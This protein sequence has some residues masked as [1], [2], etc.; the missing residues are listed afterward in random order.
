MFWISNI[1]LLIHQMCCT[2]SGLPDAKQNSSLH[3]LGSF[4]CH[5]TSTKL[6]LQWSFFGRINIF[7]RVL[8]AIH[9]WVNSGHQSQCV[10]FVNP[11]PLQCGMCS[12]WKAPMGTEW[13]GPATYWFVGLMQR[14]QK[15]PVW[16]KTTRFHQSR[17]FEL[18]NSITLI[19]SLWSQTCRM[20]CSGPHPPPPPPPCRS[21]R[22]WSSGNAL[23]ERK[24][25]QH[26]GFDSC[27]FAPA[28]L[29]PEAEEQVEKLIRILW[30]SAPRRNWHD[31]P[32]RDGWGGGSETSECVFALC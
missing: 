8:V 31:A 18:T 14:P 7:L 28:G 10:C 11:F 5:M 27:Q 9:R 15:L 24:L 32:Q 30:L 23:D 3:W 26:G 25:N 4:S 13:E 20:D 17:H 6:K 12:V 21:H 22:I 2:W 16:L 1:A 29:T 19:S